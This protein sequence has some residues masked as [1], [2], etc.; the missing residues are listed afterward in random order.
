MA[1]SSV[2]QPRA[3][4]HAPCIHPTSVDHLSAHYSMNYF[5]FT[6]KSKFTCNKNLK[7]GAQ[8]Y[9]SSYTFSVSY[10]LE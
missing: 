8:G 1:P 2:S 9:G 5:I 10:T 7:F 3:T 6:F 4:V